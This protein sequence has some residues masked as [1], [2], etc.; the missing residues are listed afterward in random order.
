MPTNL[1]GP[2]DHYDL[3]NSHVLPALLRKFHEAKINGADEVV[4]WGDGEPLREFLYV[5]DLAEARIFL[6]HNY[7]EDDI[8]NVGSG[9]EVSVRELAFV[10][11]DVFGFSG[12]L[13]FDTSKSNGTIRQKLDLFKIA[14]LVGTLRPLW[15]KE[16]T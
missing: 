15:L 10:F 2:N 1:Y 13:V 5:A 12:D 9:D 6:M 14:I 3:D 16:L 7:S 11:M 4:L 8:I